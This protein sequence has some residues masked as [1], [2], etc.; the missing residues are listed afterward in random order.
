[1]L[2][3]PERVTESVFFEGEARH[4]PE[5]GEGTFGQDHEGRTTSVACEL[6][7]I[8]PGYLKFDPVGMSTIN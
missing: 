3:A 8:K 7:T 2:H 6:D 5:G 1:M 4:V